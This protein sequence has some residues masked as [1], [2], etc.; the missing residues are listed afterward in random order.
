MQRGVKIADFIGKI[1]KAMAERIYS[2]GIFL[3]LSKAFD[4]IDHKILIKKIGTWTHG[5]RGN[6]QRTV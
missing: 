6:C 3:N 5:I 1:T 4:T 2:I